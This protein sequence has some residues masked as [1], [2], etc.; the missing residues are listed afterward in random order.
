MSTDLYIGPVIARAGRFG[1]DTFSQDEGLRSSFR[2]PRVEEA[3]Y[4]RRTMIAEAHRSAHLRVHICETLAEFDRM[5][6][7]A[8]DP[9]SNAGRE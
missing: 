6:E 9:A 2:Y 3:H 1:Y 7:T 5:C 8:G 4:D